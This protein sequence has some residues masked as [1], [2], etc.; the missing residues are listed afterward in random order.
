[1]LIIFDLDGTLIDSSRDLAIST[2][3]T[4]EHFGLLPLDQA[5]INSYVGSGAGVLIE[6]AMGPGKP[7]KLVREALEFFLKYYR[8]HALEHTKMYGGVRELVD[9]L[10]LDHHR[11]GVLTNKPERISIDILSALHLQSHFFRIFGGNSFAEK[12]PH[13]V[14]ITTMMQETGIAASQTIMVGDSGVDIQTARNAEVASC[15]V[16]WGFQPETFNDA[17]PDFLIDKPVDLLSIV[18]QQVGSQR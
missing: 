9:K 2:N 5:M 15:G 8:A 7:E 3:A 16:T 4:L 14:G 17:P 13:P 18:S 11:L 6:R 1:M 10:S 12:K